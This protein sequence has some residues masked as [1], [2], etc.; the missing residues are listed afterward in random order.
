MNL[1][2]PLAPPTPPARLEA[3]R[4]RLRVVGMTT[5]RPPAS[6]AECQDGP[7]PC[8]YV[9]CRY[10]LWRDPGPHGWVRIRRG[11]ESCALDV[12]E[13]GPTKPEEIARLTGLVLRRVEQIHDETFAKLR[14]N[15]EARALLEA[16]LGG[17]RPRRS[18]RVARRARVWI[19]DQL[20]A[21][22][23]AGGEGSLDEDDGEELA[24]P[25]AEDE[26]ARLE[27]WAAIVHALMRAG[28]R[29]A[30]AWRVANARIGD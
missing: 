17:P 13:R 3:P 21:E 25:P 14:R 16:L 20:E 15:P 29:M 27:R 7:R 26:E 6:R 30:L 10:H 28:M 23:S 19:G 5:L 12:A 8:P 22:S 2:M 1:A 24:A 18:K 9:T 11:P 4:R